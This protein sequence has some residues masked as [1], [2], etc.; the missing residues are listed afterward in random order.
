MC[1]NLFVFEL[2]VVLLYIL[3]GGGFVCIV[4]VSCRDELDS[5]FA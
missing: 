1:N 3:V 2:S 4:C 5:S